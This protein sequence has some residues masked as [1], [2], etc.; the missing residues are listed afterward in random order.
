[1]ELSKPKESISYPALSPPPE[2]PRFESPR[3]P[4]VKSEPYTTIQ[5]QMQV[6]PLAV[7]SYASV[8][9]VGPEVRPE[10]KP[11]MQAAPG[12][13]AGMQV[14]PAQSSPGSDFSIRNEIA[15]GGPPPRKAGWFK[16]WSNPF[17]SKRMKTP[18]QIAIEAGKT[19]QDLREEFGSGPDKNIYGLCEQCGVTVHDFFQRGYLPGQLSVLVTWQE[20]I[21]L[22]LCDKMLLSDNGYT[23]WTA[24]SIAQAFGISW[25]DVLS[26]FSIPLS[27]GPECGVNIGSIKSTKMTLP[28]AVRVQFN[29]D[30]II[31]YKLAP[32]DVSDILGFKTWRDVKEFF[33]I[34][35][36]DLPSLRSCGWTDAYIQAVFRDYTAKPDTDVYKAQPNRRPP[37]VQ[38]RN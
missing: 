19:V 38:G 8:E 26:T 15:M 33:A 37:I 12:V 21:R 5:P 17:G 29:K 16:E 3:P 2:V 34:S 14:A 13:Q 10:V 30:V 18:L 31:A 36:E 23:R 24:V 35:S 20:A 7:P 25:I 28:E 9:K 27:K 4:I 6:P 1:M 11:Y 32:I 22:G